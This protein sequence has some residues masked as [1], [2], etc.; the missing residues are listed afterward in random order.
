MSETTPTV[1]GAMEELISAAKEL[2]E[3]S[4]WIS[5][6]EAAQLGLKIGPGNK[7]R[8]ALEAVLAPKP[9][10][11][12][13]IAQ[14]RWARL[15]APNARFSYGARKEAPGE[16]LLFG[17]NPEEHWGIQLWSINNGMATDQNGNWEFLNNVE[18]WSYSLP[19]L[20]GSD[21]EAKPIPIAAPDEAQRALQMV[22]EDL[23]TC[24]DESG[25]DDWKSKELSEETIEAVIAVMSR[26]RP[27][28]PKE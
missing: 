4:P 19:P 1:S 5:C 8:D 12:M 9:I 3:I 26:V 2:V 7:L 24:N 17:S 22:F 23:E 20:P 25:R 14:Q 13:D 10:A 28:S 11:G 27:T 21:A 6:D 18:W 16:K 15:A